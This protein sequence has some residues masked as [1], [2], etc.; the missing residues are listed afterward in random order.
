MKPEQVEQV[1]KALGADPAVT[2]WSPRLK[3]GAMFSNF[4]ET[5]SIRV[6]GVDPAREAATALLRRVTARRRARC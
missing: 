4:T 3:F 2:A 5:T 6:N 1:E